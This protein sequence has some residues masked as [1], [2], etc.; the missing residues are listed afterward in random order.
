MTGAYFMTD[1]ELKRKKETVLSLMNDPM[2]SPM[3]IKDI[4]V[5]LDIPKVQR[6]ELQEVLDYLVSFLY[7]SSISLL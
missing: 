6:E 4:A 3:K 7:N 1:E 5:F 2:Y